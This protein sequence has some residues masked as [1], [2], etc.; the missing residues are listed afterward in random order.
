MCIVVCA[1][2]LL[3]GLQHKNRCIWGGWASIS[4]NQLHNT[5]P[6]STKVILIL[7]CRWRPDYTRV[8][9]RRRL[10]HL[11]FA[12]FH[13]QKIFLT[14]LSSLLNCD[15]CIAKSESSL[16]LFFLPTADMLLLVQDN[17]GNALSFSPAHVGLH[18]LNIWHLTR[19]AALNFKASPLDRPQL[20]PKLPPSAA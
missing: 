6:S 4:N 3:P 14:L 7:K 19:C 16:C 10:A 13:K 8:W 1:K 17:G 11:I 20:V 15:L 12:S 2:N 5:I 9:F 18:D